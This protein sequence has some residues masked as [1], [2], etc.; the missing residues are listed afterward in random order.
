MTTIWSATACAKGH[1]V[2]TTIMVVPSAASCFMTS[3]TSPTSSGSSADV[4]SSNSMSSGAIA[5]AR[6][7]A[8]RCCWPP[9][10]CAE[11]DP[12][13]VGKADLSQRSWAMT[14]ASGLPS[15]HDHRAGHDILQRRHMRKRSNC[16][17]T[18]PMRPTEARQFAAVWHGTLVAEVDAAVADLQ[19]ARR[20]LFQEIDAA[21]E[22]RLAAAR[23]A[24]HH[25]NLATLDLERHAAHGLDGAVALT[26]ALGATIAWPLLVN[27]R[28]RRAAHSVSG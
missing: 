20:R 17:N 14:S 4:T 6:A 2:V 3:S 15:F 11:S 21:Q 10:G 24:D 18:M 23:R 26:Q 9:D 5:M 27:A 19:R 1:L 25:D 8:T 12:G 16:W 22:G 13:K 7:M 28:S